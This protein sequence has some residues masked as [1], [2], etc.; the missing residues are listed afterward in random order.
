MFFWLMK[1]RIDRLLFWSCGALAALALFGIMW[2][3]VVDVIGRKFFNRSVPGGL[4]LTEIMMVC[5]IFAALPLVSWRGEHVVFD[6]L[7]RLIPAPVRALQIRVVHLVC[8]LVFGWMAWLMVLKGER[9]A[10]YGETTSYL[11]LPLYPVAWGMGLL[12]LLAGLV[13]VALA[14]LGE[15]DEGHAAHAVHAGEVAAGGPT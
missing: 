10:S 9:Y 8:A 5:V 7:D 14:I 1:K 3:T 11:L 2:L 13:H 6:T 4:E 15:R 12:L